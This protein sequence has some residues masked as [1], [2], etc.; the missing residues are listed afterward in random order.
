MIQTAY[1]P[2][3]IVRFL[4]RLRK[5][6]ALLLES[7]VSEEDEE[8]I[9]QR[10]DEGTSSDSIL[11]QQFYGACSFNP[12]RSTKERVAFQGDLMDMHH[13]LVYGRKT[14]TIAG[15]SDFNGGYLDGSGQCAEFNR[16][17]GMTFDE[18]GTLYIADS[19]N[20]WYNPS[21]HRGGLIYSD[22]S[23]NDCSVRRISPDLAWVT[24]LA[25]NG[26]PGYR[27][28][29]GSSALFNQTKDV[30]ITPGGDLI[31]SDLGNHVIRCINT[32]TNV[33]TT[34]A[35]VAGKADY[36]DGP[37][38]SAMFD[39]PRG[40]A[41]TKRDSH[42][43]VSDAGNF[44][45]RRISPN[46][47]VETVAGKG[48][49]PPTFENDGPGLYAAFQDP[50]YLAVDSKDRI[51][52]TDYGIGLVR[53][54]T[55][56]GQ[57]RSPPPTLFRDKPIHYMDR[58]VLEHQYWVPMDRWKKEGFKEDYGLF[59][60][61]PLAFAYGI[62]FDKNDTL[63]IVDDEMA[64]IQ[65]MHK[66]TRVVEPY[67]GTVWPYGDTRDGPARSATFQSPGA[68]CA[69]PLAPFELYV[70]D[71]ESNTIRK[72]YQGTV[73][74][75]DRGMEAHNLLYLSEELDEARGDDV[76]PI[77][78]MPFR[79]A[80][81]SGSPRFKDGKKVVE[82]VMSGKLPPP[83]RE[84]LHEEEKWVRLQL[85]KTAKKFVSLHAS[86]H[87]A[88][89]AY[90]HISIRMKW[91]KIQKALE[92]RWEEMEDFERRVKIRQI[93]EAEGT[94][95]MDSD[96]HRV[97]NYYSPAYRRRVKKA[98]GQLGMDPSAWGTGNGGLVDD[99][100]GVGHM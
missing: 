92:K 84:R 62:C 33:V 32:T 58:K 99:D 74:E 98:G 31:V 12:A 21:C 53:R 70:S 28:G 26:E 64:T 73:P 59:D 29:A 91:H 7:I 69:H 61:N 13:E 1:H 72:I 57:C 67:A 48:E 75:S 100:E 5:D 9:D 87:H 16:P 34:L 43:Y 95:E 89:R 18:S 50:T 39:T 78:K 60:G 14:M 51:Y 6:K 81:C 19:M 41:V 83:M 30:A 4:P 42:I 37:G 55:P 82:T 63:Y 85:R 97:L 24:T 77:P 40:V 66:K 47:E 86:A 17:S 80:S 49:V 36:R 35:G 22:L 54:I 79:S 52:V 11:S 27:D 15:T 71:F 93:Q 25:G 2:I 45:I 88:K 96:G 10:I 90:I 46:G 94:E 76:G 38:E 44:R 56:G 3:N 65:V 68:I 20:H 23:W 8:N